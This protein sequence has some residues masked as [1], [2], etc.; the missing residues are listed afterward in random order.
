MAQGAMAQVSS[1]IGEA[2][3]NTISLSGEMLFII[4]LFVFLFGLGLWL[5]RAVVVAVGIALFSSFALIKF[6]IL[7]Y[8]KELFIPGSECAAEQ[9]TLYW[10]LGALLVLTVVLYFVLI[11]VLAYLDVETGFLAWLKT[12]LLALSLVGMSIVIL[13]SLGLETVAG[14]GPITEWLFG[15]SYSKITLLGLPFVILFFVRR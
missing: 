10:T 15:V 12:G 3:G 9:E 13:G 11:R 4:F 5:G 7:E 8:G 6:A 1:A 14:L 2:T